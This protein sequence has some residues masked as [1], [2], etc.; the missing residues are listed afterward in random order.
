MDK[1]DLY[2]RLN[3]N[4]RTGWLAPDGTFSGCATW[5]HWVLPTILGITE[6]DL[7]IRGYIKIV[8]GDDLYYIDPYFHITEAQYKYLLDNGLE[9]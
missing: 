4:Y 3:N 1:E 5:D 6:N 2:Q 7:E 9:K 8:Q